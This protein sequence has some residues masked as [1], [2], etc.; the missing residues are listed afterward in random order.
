MNSFSR[1]GFLRHA[2]VVGAAPAFRSSLVGFSGWLFQG[3]RPNVQFPVPPRERIA[4]NRDNVSGR[5]CASSSVGTMMERRGL[6]A[7]F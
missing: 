4:A 7:R 1:R 3:A 2:A 6:T 5:L